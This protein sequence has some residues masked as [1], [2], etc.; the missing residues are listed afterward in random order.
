[1]D[2]KQPENAERLYEE[3][4]KPKFSRLLSSLGLSK[5]Y[6]RATGNY[7]ISESGE[8]VLDCISG[9][10]SAILGHNHPELIRAL[11]EDLSAGVPIVAQGSIHS[12]TALLAERLNRF[13]PGDREYFVHFSNSGTESVEAAIKHAYK[14]HYD[15]IEK[16]YERITRILD[17]FY[18]QYENSEERP[19]L[20]DDKKLIDFRDD[21]DEYNLQQFESFKDKPVVISMK[22][23]YHGK[24]ASSLKVTFNKSFREPFEG[25]SAVQNVFIDPCNP[26]RIPE[27]VTQEVCAFYYPIVLN[28]AVTLKSIRMTRVMG[29]IFEP[30]MGEGG[31]IPLPDSTMGSLAKI[32][33]ELGLPYI[34]DEIQTGCGRLGEIFSYANTPLSSISPDYILLSK[35]LGGGVVKIGATLIRKDI[36]EQDFGILHTSTFGEDKLSSRTA[37]KVLDLLTGENN[38]VLKTVKEKGDYLLRR[39]RAIQNDFPE[40]I[41]DVRGKGLM[42][43]VEF[44]SLDARSPFF[45]AAGKQGV[46]SL[47]VSSYLMHHHRIRVLAPIS[48]MLKGNPG[49]KRL[50]IIRIQPSALIEPEEMD[51]LV[52]ALREACNIINSNNEYCL[53]GHLAGTPPSAEERKE[54]LV[55]DAR[56]PMNDA[57]RHIDARA[58]FVLHPTT[59]ER[60]VEY[61]FPS[62]E[63][64]RWDREKLKSW[65]HSISRFLEPVHVKNEYISSND[66]VI[67]L[68]LVFVPY[69]PEYVMKASEAYLQKEIRDKIQDA[70]TIARELGDDNIPVSIVGLGAYTSIATRNG[71]STK[72]YEMP[73]TTGNAYTVGLSI[74]GIMYAAE[75]RG[76]DLREAVVAVVG[77][78]GNI[79]S[80]VAQILAAR[81]GRL[82]LIGSGNGAQSR[83]RLEYTR[84]QCIRELLDEL[85]KLKLNAISK[86]PH[87]GKI[88]RAV[89][90]HLNGDRAASN[91]NPDQ[92]GADDELLI[93]ETEA[94]LAETE[95]EE[96]VALHTDLTRLKEADII[97]VATNSPDE[98]LIRPS[99][100]KSGAIICGTSV[101]SNLSREFRDHPDL[102][103]FDGGFASL[104]DDSVIN[105]VGMPDDGLA[106]GCLA[107]TLA[108]G[109]DGQNHSF[110]K[111]AVTSKQVYRIME[112]AQ[113]YGFDLGTLKL[114]DRPVSIP[115]RTMEA[116]HV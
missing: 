91:G 77:A 30:V 42:I 37:L 84:R 17:D 6:I 75:R 35:S 109:F 81:V 97:I 113:T 13:V 18:Y 3:Y 69:L 95:T 65:W 111:G 59:V 99:D 68:S 107:E 85:A 115:T 16:E 50:S 64:Y 46:L 67:E 90:E 34:I 71:E 106:Y 83:F 44:T 108:L 82:M 27:I 72:Y 60:L 2:I 105:F 41:K 62:F 33:S 14:V 80:V 54:C 96:L 86:S 21:L 100:L 25:L 20:P 61:Y 56:Y 88:S 38:A 110:S 93:A 98:S 76:V 24:T 103:A 15:K 43:G 114:D 36:Y 70:V 40:V 29:L 47:L 23:A 7:L 8:R 63:S 12:D 116:N 55:F 19:S 48:T 26:Q 102:F 87:H 11:I 101:P 89:F 45:R 5:N 112:I 66:F 10:G 9:F 73:I 22:G 32:H 92:N 74:Q 104:P 94:Y 1:M 51:R 58:G 57:H 53:V 49:K 31:I 79:G 4:C 28:G 39:L 52:D 78:G